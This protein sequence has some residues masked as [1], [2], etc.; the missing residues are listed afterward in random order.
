METQDMHSMHFSELEFQGPST[1]CQYQ[2]IVE[3]QETLLRCI[4]DTDLVQGTKT[5]INANAIVLSSTKVAGGIT[6]ATDRTSM[7]ATF[8]DHVHPLLMV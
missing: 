5:M 1:F 4:M 6:L 3:L 7:V 8:I 2:D